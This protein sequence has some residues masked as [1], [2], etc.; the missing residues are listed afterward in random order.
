MRHALAKLVSRHFEDT[1]PGL[2]LERYAKLDLGEGKVPNDRR[3]E[4]MDAV[5]GIQVPGVYRAAFK[6]WRAA[7][8]SRALTVEVQ[9]DARILLGHGNPAPLGVGL[10]LHPTYGVPFLP[11]TALKGVLNHF[12]AT[13][14][15]AEAGSPWAGVEYD[16]GRPSQAPGRF[17]LALFGAPAIGEDDPGERGRVVFEDALYVPGSASPAGSDLPLAPD[18][19]TPHQAEYYRGA[20]AEPIDWDDPVPVQ[21]VTVRPHARFLLGITPVEPDDADWAE[22]ALRYLL[23][24]LSVRGIGGKTAAGYGRL[25]VPTGGKVRHPERASAAGSD[26]RDRLAAEV[27]RVLASEGKLGAFA[28]VDWEG[29]WAAIPAGERGAASKAFEPIFKH[30]KFRKE[31][32]PLGRVSALPGFIR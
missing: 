24:A 3:P 1:H 10:T 19:L 14:L 8:Q 22:L 31:K 30:A 18:V 6:R 29:L 21:F 17:H 11:A 7:L 12:L 5:C 28:A 27:Q 23:D 25:S 2:W 13:H 16:Q 32:D 15:G 4:L 9:A 26:A 20:A